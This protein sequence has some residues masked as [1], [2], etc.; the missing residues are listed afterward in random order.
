LACT[1]G[2]HV[3]VGDLAPFVCGFGAEAIAV[4]Q[5]EEGRPAP[6]GVTGA[7][8]PSDLDEA[9]RDQ[10]ADGGCDCLAVYPVLDELGEGDW[11]SAVI[12]AAV[13]GEFDLDTG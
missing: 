3:G 9:E 13:V 10:F 12:V 11:Q 4:G 2:E 7:S 1:F 8:L 6:F 5:T